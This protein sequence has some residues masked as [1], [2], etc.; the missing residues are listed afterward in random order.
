VPRAVSFKND[1]T[2]T[3]KAV[4]YL[5]VMVKQTGTCHRDARHRKLYSVLRSLFFDVVS[6][7]TETQ[8][9]SRKTLKI[10]TFNTMYV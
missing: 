1:V 4:T 3:T 7:P 10:Y 2:S 9:Y 8:P 5:K 6:R